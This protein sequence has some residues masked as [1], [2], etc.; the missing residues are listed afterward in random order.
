MNQRHQGQKAVVG[1]AED[2]DLAVG[3]GDVLDQPV[4]GVVGVGGFVDGRGVQR[5]VEG[6]VHDVVALGAVLAA[7]VLDDADVAAFDD[8][9]G[10]VVVAVQ[11]GPEVRAGG[12][13]G[14]RVGVVGRA[15]EQD[16]RVLGAFGDQDHG[17]QTGRRRAWGS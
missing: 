8:H 1:D 12:M 5:A 13:A 15:G 17:V 16:G 3:L 10:G 2:A 7:D 9:V 14:E 11:D 4:D 6:A